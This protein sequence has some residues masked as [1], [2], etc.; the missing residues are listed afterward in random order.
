MSSSMMSRSGLK[1]RSSSQAARSVVAQAGASRPLWLP[2]NTP[3][4]HLTGEMAGDFG[5]DPL[6]LGKDPASLAFYKEAE[7]VHCRLAMTGVA[8]VLFTSVANKAG[9]G[10]PEWFDAGKVYDAQPNHIPFG[11]LLMVQLFLTGF[12]ESKRWQDLNKPGS[13]GEKGSFFGFEGAFKGTGDPAYPGGPFDPLGL[14]RGS[15]EA[16]QQYKLKEIKNGRLAMLAFI[17]FGAQ[18]AATGK[19]PIDNLLEHIA[20]PWHKTFAENGVSLPFT[21]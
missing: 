9:A 4:A 5:F 7:L 3:P 17:G 11:T 14:S 6:G 19:G 20:D 2:G 13:Q 18:H 12:V 8:G 1:L 15:P 16:L 10:I 21:L